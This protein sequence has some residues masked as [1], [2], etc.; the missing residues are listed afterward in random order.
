MDLKHIKPPLSQKTKKN[1][2]EIL[3]SIDLNSPVKTDNSEV[4][5]K[6]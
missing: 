4:N 6:I 3:K 5:V 1:N 2:V